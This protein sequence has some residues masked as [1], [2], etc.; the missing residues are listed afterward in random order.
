MRLYHGEDKTHDPRR[1]ASKGKT[2]THA[3]R[4]NRYCY[5]FLPCKF[6]LVGY[7]PC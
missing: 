3:M 1:R 6:A 4:L 5:L 7:N 2:E